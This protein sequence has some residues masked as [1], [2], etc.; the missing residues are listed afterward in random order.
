MKKLLLATVVA[1]FTLTGVKAQEKSEGFQG[2][3]WALGQLQYS[4]V[5]KGPQSFSIL[6]V[7]GTFVTSDVTVGLGLGYESKKDYQEKAVDAFVVMPLA[8]KYWAVSDNF[9]IFGQADVPLKFMDGA[10]AYGFNLRPGVDF[11]VSKKLTLE[12]TFGQFGYNAVKPKNGDAVGTTSLGF[13]SMNVNFGLKL[14][15]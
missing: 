4:S 5:E 3:W 15:L 13:N 10:T 11:F 1:V 12:A 2:V 14:I 9:F 7:V 6:P 8:R